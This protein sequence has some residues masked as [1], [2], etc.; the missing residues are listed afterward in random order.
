MIAQ[1]ADCCCLLSLG[2]REEPHPTWVERLQGRPR[3]AVPLALLLWLLLQWW[4]QLLLLAWTPL[5]G[6]AKRAAL[7]ALPVLLAPG[8]L[9]PVACVVVVVGWVG[10]G[11]WGAPLRGPRA[12]GR[13]PAPPLPPPHT[14]PPIRGSVGRLPEGGCLGRAVDVRACV[15]ACVCRGGGEGVCVC[16]GGGLAYGVGTGGNG[17]EGLVLSSVL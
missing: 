13:G 7:L 4:W 9:P 14:P 11:S 12:H 3:K 15:R 5:P 10:G 16:V 2:G 6:P 8:G 1:Y 17:G